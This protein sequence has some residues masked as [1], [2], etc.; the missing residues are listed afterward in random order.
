MGKVEYTPPNIKFMLGYKKVKFY[1]EFLL[2]VGQGG[3]EFVPSDILLILNI[4]RL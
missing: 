4:T 1:L 2:K 3:K